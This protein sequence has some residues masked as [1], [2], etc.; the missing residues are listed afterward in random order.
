MSRPFRRGIASSA[1]LLICT[2]CASTQAAAQQRP[3]Q[4]QHALDTLRY[5]TGWILLGYLDNQSQLWA[6]IPKQRL[7]DR[8]TGTDSVVPSEGDVLEIAQ[9]TPVEIA[10]YGVRG[11]DDRF[12]PPRGSFSKDNLTPVTLPPGTEVLVAE[13]V[14][15]PGVNMEAIWAR[16]LRPAPK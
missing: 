7:R 2:A 13:I 1:L 9:N 5:G 10:N 14:R 4:P 8:R 6:T 15:D 12:V 16:G 3:P 11:E